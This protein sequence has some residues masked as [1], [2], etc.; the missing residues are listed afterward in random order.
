[1]AAAVFVLTRSEVNILRLLQARG[2]P[3][4]RRTQHDLM[5]TAGEWLNANTPPGTVVAF[6]SIGALPYYA[7]RPIIDLMG[8]TDRHIARMSVPDMGMDQRG[9]RR[10]TVNT[11][12]L[13]TPT[14]FSSTRD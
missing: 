10:A 5:R 1:M 9:T 8:L 6:A 2:W 14:S 12:C 4:V 11:S 7:D 13:A 3:Q